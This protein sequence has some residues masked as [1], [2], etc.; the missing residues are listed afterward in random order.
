[1]RKKERPDAT[2]IGPLEKRC[3]AC[4]SSIGI[5]NCKYVNSGQPDR[6]RSA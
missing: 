4:P 6:G 5:L 3:N 2:N 1:M